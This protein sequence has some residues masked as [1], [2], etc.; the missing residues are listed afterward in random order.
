MRVHVMAI[1]SKE[2]QSIGAP[3][4]R[5]RLNQAHSMTHR[6]TC[7]YVGFD[8]GPEDCRVGQSEQIVVPP[9]AQRISDLPLVFLSLSAARG[10]GLL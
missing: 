8:K 3:A 5:D 10:L 1:M 4:L 7:Y 9:N 2:V 6:L